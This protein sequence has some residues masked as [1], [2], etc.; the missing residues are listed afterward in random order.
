MLSATTIL[1]PCALILY[2]FIRKRRKPV[3]L[4]SREPSERKAQL[5]ALFPEVRNYY[6]DATWGRVRQAHVRPEILEC[7]TTLFKSLRG[8]NKYVSS[9]H[10][11]M[12]ENEDFYVFI[13]PE[14]HYSILMTPKRKFKIVHL[15]PH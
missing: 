9:I 1:I 14:N 11:L 15:I 13:A 8:K 2:W 7:N 12:V 3:I 4:I 6:K 5:L 10:Y